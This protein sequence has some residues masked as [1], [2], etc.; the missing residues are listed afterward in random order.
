MTEYIGELYPIAL[1][2]G[3]TPTLFWEYSIQEITDIIDSRNR[4][5]EF[6]RKN[7][8]IRDYYLAKRLK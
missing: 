2:V 5:L 4:V 1:D 7:E 3:I 8:Y 6:N